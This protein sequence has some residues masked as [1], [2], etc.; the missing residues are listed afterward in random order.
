[1]LFSFNR[2]RGEA[3]R[4]EIQNKTPLAIVSART[5]SERASLHTSID[6]LPCTTTP[7]PE[8]WLTLPAQNIQ[9][10]DVKHAYPTWAMTYCSYLQRNK[11]TVI[12]ILPAKACLAGVPVSTRVRPKTIQKGVFGKVFEA[13]TKYAGSIYP[14]EVVRYGLNTLPN[15]PVCFGVKSIPVPDTS[16][17]SVRTKNTPGTGV[18]HRTLPSCNV[19]SAGSDQSRFGARVP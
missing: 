9:T 3:Y 18:P 5:V 12:S 16:V 19:Y 6:A 11:Q 7:S 10:Q 1:M 13:A 14:I 4:R 17:N 15:T 8:K 2:Q